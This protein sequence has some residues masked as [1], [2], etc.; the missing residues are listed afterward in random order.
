MLRNYC[1]AHH[2]KL[3]YKSP[4]K[5]FQFILVLEVFY[6]I[7]FSIEFCYCYILF[8][9]HNIDDIDCLN[10]PLYILIGFTNDPWLLPTTSL[11]TSIGFVNVSIKENKKY[12]EN[13]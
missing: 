8:K 9:R 12:T 10:F 5:P 4:N 1:D 13:I 3:L 11:T 2:Q 7:F 6:R